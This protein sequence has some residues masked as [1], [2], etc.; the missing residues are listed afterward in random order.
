[1]PTTEDLRRDI[2]RLQLLV[3]QLQE[4]I[5]KLEAREEKAA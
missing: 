1:M 5:E 2:L 4:R 3:V